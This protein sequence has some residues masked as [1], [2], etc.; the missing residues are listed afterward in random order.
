MA[1]C[2][3]AMED[4]EPGGGDLRGAGG[5]MRFHRIGGRVARAAVLDPSMDVH[6]GKMFS[7]AIRLGKC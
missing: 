5:P 3:K 1:H 2:F 7:A 4:F 6:P